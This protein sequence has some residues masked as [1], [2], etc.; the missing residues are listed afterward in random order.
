M[1][2]THS[3]FWKLPVYIFRSI[4]MAIHPTIETDSE[5][6]CIM[7]TDILINVTKTRK[8]LGCISNSHVTFFDKN[9]VF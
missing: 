3:T 5:S 4:K 6:L 2:T 8:W 7:T 9:L 1:N